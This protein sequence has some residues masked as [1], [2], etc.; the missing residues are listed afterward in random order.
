MKRI[1]RLESKI[2]SFMSDS[3]FEG[4]IYIATSAHADLTDGKYE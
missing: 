3:L 1:I 4:H 2:F